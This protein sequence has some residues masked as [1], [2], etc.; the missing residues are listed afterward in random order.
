MIEGFKLKITSAELKKHCNERACYHMDRAADFKKELPKVRESMEALKKNG[1]AATVS[2]MSKGGGY[3]IDPVDDMESKIRDHN[4]KSLV[5]KFF[6]D[7]LFQEDYN[8]KEE[9][10]VRLEVLKR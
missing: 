8:L 2:Q 1:L 9:D 6:A 7:H 5:F 10:L 3:E 4:N